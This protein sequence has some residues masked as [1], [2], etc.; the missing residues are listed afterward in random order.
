MSI[1]RFNEIP[2][3]FVKAE[4][5]VFDP[6]AQRPAGERIVD[7]SY[8][9]PNKEANKILA[10][11]AAAQI[12]NDALYDNPADIAAGTVNVYA[13]QRGRDLAELTQQMR[14]LEEKA[15]KQV[16]DAIENKKNQDA[17]QTESNDV[18]DQSSLVQQQSKGE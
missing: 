13:R 5:V 2:S 17:V 4:F 15:Q 9:V 8:Y 6:I 10:R 18:G 3:Q 16:N 11:Q 14:Q 1:K 7:E 12:L